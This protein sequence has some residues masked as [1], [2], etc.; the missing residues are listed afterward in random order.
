M[1]MSK[2]S[3]NFYLGVKNGYLEQL[4]GL[5]CVF[6]LRCFF[7]VAERQ[8]SS[9]ESVLPSLSLLISFC[10]TCLMLFIISLSCTVNCPTVSH[11][12]FINCMSPSFTLLAL[13]RSGFAP[14]VHSPPALFAPLL[15]LPAF[16]S[17]FGCSAVFFCPGTQ[18]EDVYFDLT[19]PL[20]LRV[21]IWVSFSCF[22]H[23]QSFCFIQT[24]RG[25]MVEELLGK[26]GL[27]EYLDLHSHKKELSLEIWL[28]A[29]L[30]VCLMFFEF[31]WCWGSNSRS[32]FCETFMG[33]ALSSQ[34]G[35]WFATQ[36]KLA[37][38]C[39]VFAKNSL[40]EID[41]HSGHGQITF[42]I[43]ALMFLILPGL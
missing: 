9:V 4:H 25:V 8:I 2:M 6:S 33:H 7:D 24:L 21:A 37:Q 11:I 35:G 12:C 19:Y 16:T 32:I 39:G 43:P 13:A 1:W 27:H 3:N 36:F 41:S 14:S 28:E 23:W 20:E 22:L 42:K 38:V 26:T 10:P 34:I 30:W 15:E 31:C 40:T 29:L 17:L 5:S 18:Q